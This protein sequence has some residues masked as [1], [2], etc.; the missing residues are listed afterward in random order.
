MSGKFLIINGG[1]KALTV[2]GERISA[3][4]AGEVTLEAEALVSF[5]KRHPLVSVY[6]AAESMA[7]AKNVKR[8]GRA[9]GVAIP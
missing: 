9:L 6:Y 8:K 4:G 2:A 5:L 1:R 7:Q 3:K